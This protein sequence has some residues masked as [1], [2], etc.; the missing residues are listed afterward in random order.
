MRQPAQVVVT[1][2]AALLVAIVAMLTAL[3][4]ADFTVLSTSR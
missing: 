3:L 1:V 4:R 2:L